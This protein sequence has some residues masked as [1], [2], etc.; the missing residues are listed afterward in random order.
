M[1]LLLRTNWNDSLSLAVIDAV[2]D[3]SECTDSED[4][5]FPDFICGGGSSSHYKASVVLPSTLTGPDV[6]V[7]TSDRGVFIVFASALSLHG[8]AVSS[9]KKQQN[10]KTTTNLSYAYTR[11][12]GSVLRL[13]PSSCVRSR[14]VLITNRSR[15]R[16]L[17]SSRDSFASIWSCSPRCALVVVRP[18]PLCM[19][20]TTSRRGARMSSST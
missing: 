5:H 16:P 17:L 6:V 10:E 3:N 2:I 4:D 12:T 7:R 8:S 19:L 9:A 18:L 14:C 20:W 11:K 15:Q 13:R 1:F